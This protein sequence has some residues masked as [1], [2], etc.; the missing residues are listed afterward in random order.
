MIGMRRGNVTRT[1]SRLIK[2]VRVEMEILLLVR[3]RFTKSSNH[4]F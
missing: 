1:F 2:N 3:E 4:A